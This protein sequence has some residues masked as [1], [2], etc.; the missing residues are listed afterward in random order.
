M[1]TNTVRSSLV[2]ILMLALAIPSV[3]SA[4]WFSWGCRY[5]GTWFGVMGPEDTTLAGWMVTVE[6]RS[7]FYGTNNLEYTAPVLDP[8]LPIPGTDAFLFPE[9]V[10]TSTNRGNWMRTGY[11]RFVYTTTGFGLDASR[12]PLYVAK[13]SGNITLSEDCNSDVIT[14]TVEIFP[15]VN[16]II[17]NPFTAMP[18]YTLPFPDQYAYRAF[19]DLP[20]LP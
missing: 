3:A 20:D 11:N 9:A 19:V 17:P 18:T 16:G 6:G 12:N 15:V 2:A 8:R 4:G 14:T 10:Q 1:K 13:V 7:S 5:Q